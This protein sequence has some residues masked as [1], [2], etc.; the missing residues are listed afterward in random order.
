M[1]KRELSNEVKAKILNC[2]ADI[3]RMHADIAGDRICQD[4]S[5]DP[6]KN[7]SLLFEDQERDDINFNSQIDNSNLED[8]EKGLDF[9]HD[10]MSI[11]YILANALEDLAKNT[12]N[13]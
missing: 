9:F 11:S 10:E 12:A 6:E 7:P 4:W 8:Y 13:Q 2:A 1:K 5:G 3:L